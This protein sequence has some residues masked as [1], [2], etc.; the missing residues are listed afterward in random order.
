M[1][2]TQEEAHR[3]FEYKDGDL[4]WKN[5]NCN[6]VQ[7]GD[8]AGHPNSY[9]YWRVETKYGSLAAHRIVF[10]M[11]HGFLPK[12]VDH[13]DGNKLNNKIENLRAATYH[14]NGCNSK[15]SKRNTS[16]AKNITWRKAQNNWRVRIDVCGKTINV[17]Q[18]EDLE[19]AEL[20]AV[21]AREK[22]HGAFANHG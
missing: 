20:A 2:L 6:T 1:T 17:G 22:Y 18:F 15:I 3:L 4:F 19:L 11:H 14:Q 12:V 9:G 7:N 5:C 16:G 13:I 21:M 8:K 10:L